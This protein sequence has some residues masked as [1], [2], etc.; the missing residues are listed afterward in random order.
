MADDS[1]IRGCMRRSVV[2]LLLA[3]AAV[4]GTGLAHADDG[5]APISADAFASLVA[6]FD[7]A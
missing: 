6:D 3:A 2:C 4:T 7:H 1:F 5:S